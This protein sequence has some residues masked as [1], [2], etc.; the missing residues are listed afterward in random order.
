MDGW[1]IQENIEY[2]ELT[3]GELKNNIYMLKSVKMEID[4]IKRL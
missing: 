2:C 4:Q 1:A 3:L